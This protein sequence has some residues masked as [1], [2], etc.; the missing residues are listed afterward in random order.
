M[1][2]VRL[3]SLFS[4]SEILSFKTAT[5]IFEAFPS[6]SSTNWLKVS[7]GR[8]VLG[9]GVGEADLGSSLLCL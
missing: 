4:M 8:L 9:R 3:V 5:W 2:L 1:M 6:R 7:L